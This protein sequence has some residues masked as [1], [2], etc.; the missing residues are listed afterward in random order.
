MAALHRRRP[1]AH[2]GAHA[3]DR[4][5][6]RAVRARG[7]RPRRRPSRCSPTSPT[8]ARSSRRSTPATP[9]RSA[10]AASI[11]V[12]RNPHADGSDVRRPL[13][14]SARAV[15]EAARRVQA[16]QGRRRVLARRREAPDAPAH[17]R[18]G[19]GVEGGARGAPAPARGSGEARPPQARCRAR[20]LLVPR[21]DRLRA[22]GVP[23][24]GRHDPSRSWRTTRAR[25]TRPPAT[26]S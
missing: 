6:R 11:S 20:P 14:W 22:R 2:R 13:P 25:G 8:S 24:E 10:R 18:H 26:S 5:G 3:R 17:L 12:Y 4:E 21:R 16:H 9:R 19:V 1:R 7:G 23:P 15:H